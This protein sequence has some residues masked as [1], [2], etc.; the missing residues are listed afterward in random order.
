MH[1]K[2]LFQKFSSIIMCS[3]VSVM[4]DSAIP[5]TIVCQAPLSMGFPPAR[6]W[7]QLPFPP[8]G[9]LPYSGI[10]PV[11]PETPALASRFFIC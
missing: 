10:E 4:S 2:Y 7:S 6:Y 9:D 3:A 8:L 1:S 5:W 11:S